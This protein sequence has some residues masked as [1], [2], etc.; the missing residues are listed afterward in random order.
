MVFEVV[1]FIAKELIAAVVEKSDL[2]LL[3][4]CKV[5]KWGFIP[6]VDI[7]GQV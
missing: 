4:A 3:P 6:M 2:E 1:I 5:L 7:C